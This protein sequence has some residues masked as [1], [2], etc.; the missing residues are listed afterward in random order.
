VCLFLQLGVGVLTLVYRVVI[1]VGAVPTVIRLAL[2]GFW[3]R[4]D[5][6]GARAAEQASRAS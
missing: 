6:A 5:R 1:G 4:G 3:V 2:T